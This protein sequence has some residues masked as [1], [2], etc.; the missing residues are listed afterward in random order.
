[1]ADM[2][3]EVEKGTFD[4][5]RADK[6]WW[7]YYDSV[8]LAA[9][10]LIHRLFTIPV[11]QA[12]K[13]YNMSNW[14]LAAVMPSNEKF[15]VH[16]L[17]C[18]YYTDA[19]KTQAQKQNW[20]DAMMQSFFELVINSKTSQLQLP[21][22]QLLGSAVDMVVTG[23]AAGDFNTGRAVYKGCFEL[24]I[25]IVLAANTPVYGV[26]NFTVAHN[27]SLDGDRVYMCMVG[28]RFYV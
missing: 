18:Y 4:P 16:A 7:S 17:E 1:M 26:L 11:G 23:A 21:M 27:A 20:I 25:K 9:A 6:L 28:E 2:K 15:R 19:A 24:P 10:T 13:G 14:P 22:I 5:N 8:I 3:T 12:G